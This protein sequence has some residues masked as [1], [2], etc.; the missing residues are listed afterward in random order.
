MDDQPPRP[1]SVTL[2]VTELDAARLVL[3][4]LRVGHASEMVSVLADQGLYSFT[5]GAPP[6]LDE[7]QRRYTAQVAGSGDAAEVW[8]NW[9]LRL[10]DTGTAIGFVQATIEHE[11]TLVAWTIGTPW[12]GHR[13]AIEA[14]ICMA[15][16]L[17]AADVPSLAAWIHP[18][19]RASQRVAEELGLVPTDEV[20]ED[21]E[22]RWA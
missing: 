7:L 5:G 11:Q 13:Y 14:A 6:S 20:D 19:H 2:L 10:K 18:Q 15:D 9:I 22:Q 21:G 16:W 12:Q 8:L 17:R 3:E 4:P 1:L